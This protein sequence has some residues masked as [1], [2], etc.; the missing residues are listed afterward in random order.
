MNK[1][2]AAELLKG[3]DKLETGGRNDLKPGTYKVLI[4]SVEL[5]E[6][7]EFLPY[8]KAHATVL[9]PV[10]DDVGRK[11]RDE[12]YAGSFKGETISFAFFFGDRFARD[13][14]PFL[15]AAMD[16]DASAAKGISKED[17]QLVALSIIKCDD[18]PQGV[19]DG[20]VAIQMK[21]VKSAPVQD[22]K[23]PTKMKV[24]INER[25]DRRVMLAELVEDLDAGDMKTFF[26]SEDHFLSL[27]AAEEE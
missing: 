6:T 24:Y 10:Q 25:F 5:L 13:F 11:P 21:A 18:Q 20:H 1:N 9:V 8:L 16:M 19:L 14:G 17:L 4:N 12:G 22:K 23:D 7:R 27:V 15:C 26:G 2:R 3:L